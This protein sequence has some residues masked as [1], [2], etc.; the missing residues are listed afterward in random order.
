MGLLVDGQW[1]D[2]WYDTSKSG[3]ITRVIQGGDVVEKGACSLTV[4]RNGVLS[5]DR[6]AAISGRA[7]DGNDGLGPGLGATLPFGGWLDPDRVG[8]PHDDCLA[9]GHCDGAQRERGCGLRWQECG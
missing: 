6:A 9:D 5:A 3:G 4:I 7:N 1:Q 2:K 8:A